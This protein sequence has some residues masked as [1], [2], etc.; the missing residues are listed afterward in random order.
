MKDGREVT[1]D[2]RYPMGH[3]KR[4]MTDADVRSKFRDMLSGCADE[5][6]ADRI[7]RLVAD[8]DRLEN[9]GI[10]ISALAWEDEQGRAV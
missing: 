8:L 7:M 3:A 5:R 6:R 1:S 9:V 4:Q 10:L 2:V